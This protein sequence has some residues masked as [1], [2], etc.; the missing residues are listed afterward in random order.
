[1][2][3]KAGQ[4]EVVIIEV[5]DE[6]VGSNYVWLSIRDLSGTELQKIQA[7]K[8]SDN[9]YKAVV[10]LGE[11]EYLFYAYIG[12]SAGAEI[13]YIGSEYARVVKYEVE[14]LLKRAQL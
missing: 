4:D 2:L 11:G 12:D 3:L 13:D 8:I 5:S 9:V 7:A 6:F 1:V 14:D 10:N